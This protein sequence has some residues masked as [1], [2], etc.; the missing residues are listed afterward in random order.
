MRKIT[1]IY[2]HH[3][4]SNFGNAK[5]IDLW[6][7]E[8]G[9]TEIGYH[10]VVCNGY[11]TAKDYKN[12]AIISDAIGYIDKGRNIKEI[13]SHVAGYNKESI[14]ICLIH[15]DEPYIETQ[16]ESYQLLVATLA[17]YFNVKIENIKGHCE[18]DKNKPL[19]PSLD[20]KKE[21][22][23]ISELMMN[24]SDVARDFYRIK[25]IEEGNEKLNKIN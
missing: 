2:I 3:S 24:M 18:A 21:R 20:M 22:K 11:L 5:L 16:L 25:Y 17:Q 7:R 9:F 19:C 12:G 13:G 6:H 23:I 14:G 10:Y 8:R 1:S 4:A 15:K